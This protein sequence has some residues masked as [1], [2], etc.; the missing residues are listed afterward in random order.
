M[1]FEKFPR[2]NR[3]EASCSCNVIM[4]LLMMS[5][6]KERKTAVKVL[7]NVCHIGKFMKW[8]CEREIHVIKINQEFILKMTILVHIFKQK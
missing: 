2:E 1:Y 6:A 5:Q 3:P 7:C 4:L 8:L